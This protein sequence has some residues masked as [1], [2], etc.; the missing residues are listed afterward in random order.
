M[1][2]A[3]L[4]LIGYKQIEVGLTQKS[5]RLAVLE[6][7]LRRNLS[8]EGG[9]DS[10]ERN[11]SREVGSCISSLFM[12]K[13]RKFEARLSRCSAGTMQPNRYLHGAVLSCSGRGINT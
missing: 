3:C 10:K 2:H 9:K 6:S 12:S 8:R 5:T 13:V 1:H 4:Y 11:Y 7:I